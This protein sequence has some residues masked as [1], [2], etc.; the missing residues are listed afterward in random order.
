MLS[1]HVQKHDKNPKIQL[2]LV[3]LLVPLALAGRPHFH[4]VLEASVGLIVGLAVGEVKSINGE[5]AVGLS[6]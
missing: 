2:F 6:E 5:I 3:C 1:R 4:L